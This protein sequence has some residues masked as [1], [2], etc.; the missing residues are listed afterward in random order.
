[1][2]KLPWR[3]KFSD[4]STALA[5]YWQ[6]VLVHFS[7]PDLMAL[8]LYDNLA[9]VPIQLMVFYLKSVVNAKCNPKGMIWEHE[10]MSG[11]PWILVIVAEGQIWQRLKILCRPTAGST[12]HLC[13]SFRGQPIKQEIDSA[14]CY[15][16]IH[17]NVGSISR[18]SEGVTGF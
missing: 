4:L 9:S 16:F 14:M 18:N 10:N 7:F 8:L 6:M 2:C 3:F 13:W 17:P 5:N 12:H 15:S 11:R 1:M